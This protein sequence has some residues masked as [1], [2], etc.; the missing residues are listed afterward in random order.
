MS[1]YDLQKKLNGDNT[2]ADQHQRIMQEGKAHESIIESQKSAKF[3]KDMKAIKK[4][5]KFI[6]GKSLGR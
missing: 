2:L 3:G 5:L 6:K 1:L 4:D